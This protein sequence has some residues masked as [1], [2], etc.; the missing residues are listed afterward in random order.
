[1]EYSY[2]SPLIEPLATAQVKF[3]QA[4]QS[5]REATRLVELADPDGWMS[6]AA[7]QYGSWARDLRSRCVGA[8]VTA[9]S[10]GAR[11]TALQ[12]ALPTSRAFR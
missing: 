6:P 12:A 4:A 3:A 8:A 1:M 11:M 2:R 7:T 9:D 10:A 5:M